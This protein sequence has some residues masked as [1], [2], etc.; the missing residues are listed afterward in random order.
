MANRHTHKKLRA[1][2]RARMT[3]TGESYQA[4]RNRILARPRP[5]ASA[6]DL[7]PLTV[8]GVPM[9]LAT[10]ED[11]TFQTIAVINHAARAARSFALPSVAWRWLRPRGVN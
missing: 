10:G 1:E 8:F 5:H 7:V 2:V 9:T 4:A 3:E 11:E 6:V